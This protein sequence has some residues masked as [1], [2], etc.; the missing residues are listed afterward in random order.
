LSEQ[1]F[2]ISCSVLPQSET[3]QVLFQAFYSSNTPCLEVILADGS[4]SGYLSNRQGKRFKFTTKTR[5]TSGRWNNISIGYDMQ[6]ITIQI[7]DNPVEQFKCTG[8]LQGQP[9]L[10]FGGTF[11]KKRN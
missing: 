2:T 8:L 4:L 3:K 7:N 11:P 9:I 5:L 1:S 6:H 10:V